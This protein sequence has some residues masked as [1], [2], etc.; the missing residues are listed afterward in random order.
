VL[1]IEDCLDKV[2][3]EQRQ[4]DRMGDERPVQFSASAWTTGESSDRVPDELVAEW[5]RRWTRSIHSGEEA[6][7]MAANIEA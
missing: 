5:L 2:G 6:G 4:P 1:A 3:R 7:R